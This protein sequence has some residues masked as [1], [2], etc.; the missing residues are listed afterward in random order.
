[1]QLIKSILIGWVEMET[2]DLARSH[3]KFLEDRLCQ[4]HKIGGCV[5]PSVMYCFYSKDISYIN[6]VKASCAKHSLGW[7]A[8]LA[9]RMPSLDIF[10]IP[11]RFEIVNILLGNLLMWMVKDNVIETVLCI[12][13]FIV[14]LWVK[15]V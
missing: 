3:I 14:F 5:C 10:F 13:T 9:Q 15:I 11:H 7:G 8:F 2:N 1:M 6:K 12:S 4:D